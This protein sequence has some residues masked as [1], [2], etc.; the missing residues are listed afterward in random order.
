[1]E[2]HNLAE[3]DAQNRNIWRLGVGMWQYPMK[4]PLRE[5]GFVTNPYRKLE[6]CYYIK[7]T[8]I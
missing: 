3:E 7:G 8:N 2:H 6:I 5:R 4:I 1:M